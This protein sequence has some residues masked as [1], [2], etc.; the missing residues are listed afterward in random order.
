MAKALKS[1]VHQG[2]V[3][4]DIKTD[5]I[6]LTKAGEAKLADLGLAKQ[7]TDDSSVTQ[8]GQ[9][10]GTPFYMA[11]EQVR[12]QADQ[13]DQRTDI[14]ALGGT[15]FHLLTGQPPFNGPTSP[16]IMTKHLTE[17]APKANKINPEI[18]DATTRLISRMMQKKK[19]QRVQSAKELITAL[20]KIMSG[21]DT[22]TPARNL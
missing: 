2:I 14:Y 21:E 16:V 22:S 10:V 4:R 6:L 13:I 17:P 3:H 19:E 12:G 7:M 8:S 20:E 1:A 11:P 18:S 9:A 5:N 15:L